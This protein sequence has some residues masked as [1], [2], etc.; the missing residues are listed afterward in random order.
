MSWVLAT[1]YFIF[2]RIRRLEL[3]VVL[4]TLHLNN[5]RGYFFRVK[6]RHNLTTISALLLNVGGGLYMIKDDIVITLIPL[7]LILEDDTLT[8]IRL[9]KLLLNVFS[10]IE[11]WMF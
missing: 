2:F 8:C 11:S 6:T 5:F 3:R 4:V 9:Y 7:A 10:T 1:F